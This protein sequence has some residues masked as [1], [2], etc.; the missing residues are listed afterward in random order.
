MVIKHFNE[1]TAKELH[2]IFKLRSQVFVVEQNCIY[3]DI[4]DKD[5]SAWH[6]LQWENDELVTYLRIL[7]KG[8]SYD[9][10][11]IG[12]VISHPDYRGKG[13]SRN[14]F[15]K[16]FQFIQEVLNEK[17]IRISAQAYLKSFYGSLGF[18]QVS[19]E[20]LEDGIPHVEMLRGGKAQ[21]LIVVDVQEVM[22]SYE[23]GAW[24]GQERVARIGR[25]IEQA[26]KNAVPVIYIQHSDFE[27]EFTRGHHIWNICEAIKPQKHEVVFEKFYSDA[28]KGTGLDPY[29][30]NLGISELMI[31]G[32]QTEFCMDTTIRNGFSRGYHQKGVK[33][34]HSTFDHPYMTA[35]LTVQYHEHLWH[36]RFLDLLT[37]EEAMAWLSK[38]AG[39]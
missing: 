31:V 27:G 8:I 5:P 19:E 3:Q 16:A 7:P 18:R 25:L 15:L 36:Q 23:G 1:L 4:D 35:E 20:Y 13:L 39:L 2:D 14:A 10:V 12:R 37:E 30:K 33:G 26:R 22:L 9:D 21:A 38:S 32:M 11:S 28:F 6:L 24:E 29:L 17:T 34:A